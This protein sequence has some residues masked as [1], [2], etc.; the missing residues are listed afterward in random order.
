ML[1]GAHFYPSLLPLLLPFAPLPIVFITVRHH[2]L[3]GLG[4]AAIAALFISITSGSAAALPHFLFIGL[5]AWALGYLFATP[6]VV[7]ARRHLGTEAPATVEKA[8]Y[9]F[10]SI[11]VLAAIA[12][13]PLTV[14]AVVLA[15]GSYDAST[16]AIRGMVEA[17]FRAE[18]NL[19]AGAPLALPDGTS[20]T[21][22]VDSFAR[23]MPVFGGAMAM[24]LHLV[25]LWLASVVAAQQSPTCR[26]P[27]RLQRLTLPRGTGW[28]LVLGMI[29]TLPRGEIYLLGSTLTSTIALCFALLG[30]CVIHACTMGVRGR[31]FILAAV[32]FF[33][34]AQG[35]PVVLL[36]LLGG[37]EQVFALRR[38]FSP[39]EQPS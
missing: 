31:I 21:P 32:Y 22:A 16:L 33:L 17:Y 26:P 10:G 8:W 19:T 29:L 9:S 13:A 7:L 15:T 24:V 1:V 11:I 37:A 4:A 3:N 25:N 18:L 35:W 12:T 14:L 36:A 2:M 30:L 23:M 28:L 6:S 27:P 5:P 20:L 34:L 38:R 39:P